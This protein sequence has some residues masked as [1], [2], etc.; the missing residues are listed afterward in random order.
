MSDTPFHLDVATGRYFFTKVQDAEADRNMIAR[1]ED[2]RAFVCADLRIEPPRIVWIRPAPPTSKHGALKFDHEEELDPVVRLREDA[3]GG[4]TP[5]NPQ[6]HEIWI[7]SDLAACPD[8]EYVV[9]HELRHVAQKEHFLDVFKVECRAEGDACP[10][11]YEVLK[12]YL[13]SKGSLTPELREQIDRQRTATQSWFQTRWP[14]GVFQ[15][16]QSG[17]ADTS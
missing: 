14:V 4:Y 8:L 12:R 10:Y 17:P 1:A 11:G 2:V 9:A 15:I 16:I 13:E 6:L 5:K 7:R 3:R